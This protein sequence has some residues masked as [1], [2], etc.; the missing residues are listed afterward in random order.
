MTDD[1]S[2]ESK[3]AWL[4]FG[5][6]VLLQIGLFPLMRATSSTGDGDIFDSSLY[7]WSWLVLPLVTAACGWRFYREPPWVWVVAL[8][9]PLAVEVALLGTVLHDPDDGA[10]LWIVGEFFVLAQALPIYLGASLGAHLGRR[11]AA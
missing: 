7:L 5:A 3:G 10:S 8:V 11:N 9:V 2:G 6:L 4:A 1:G